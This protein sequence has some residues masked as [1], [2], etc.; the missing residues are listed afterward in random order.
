MK[1]WR[2]I[3]A[4]V[5]VAVFWGGIVALFALLWW[6]EGYQL[7]ILGVMFVLFF[8][9]SVLI[10]WEDRRS[11]KEKA[12]LQRASLDEDQVKEKAGQTAP[13]TLPEPLFNTFPEPVPK[14]YLKSVPT[15]TQ[16]LLLKYQK[17]FDCLFSYSLTGEQRLCIV[18]D[19]Y[20][21]LVIASA[22]SGKTTTLLGKYVF[23][24]EEG[25]A[26][27][28]EILVLAFNKAIQQEIKKKIKS[29][30]P[31][32][33]DPEVHTFHGF[34]NDLIKKA[35]GRKKVDR[36]AESSSDG[37]LNTANVRTII[38]KA[39]CEYPGIE[40]WISLFRAMCPRHQIEH[41]AKNR[42]EY[43]EAFG[44]Y[45]YDRK[46]FQYNGDSP[47]PRIPSL[48][49]MYWVR[50]Q[51]ELAIIN[52]LIIR[53]VK[54]EYER[55]YPGGKFTPDFYYPEIDLWHEHFAIRRDGTSFFPR[56]EEG[57]R[58]KM[59]FYEQEEKK[60]V[61]FLYTYIYQYDEGTLL[62]KIFQKLKKEGISF[63]PPSRKIIEKWLN[64]LKSDDTYNL[65]A[66]CIKLAKANDFSK[67]WR[68][69][70]RGHYLSF[71]LDSLRDKTRSKHFKRFFLPLLET[72]E[73]ILRDN[74]TIDFEDM[75][76]RPIRHLRGAEREKLL[77]CRYK[78]VLVDE[79]QDISRS[80]QDFLAGILDPET[81]LFVVGD[82]W[83]S[84][85]GFTG[86]NSMVMREFLE[87]GSPLAP[88]GWKSGREG[89]SYMPKVYKIQ[90]TFRNCKPISDVASEFIQK[91]PAQIRK[92]VRAR[93]PQD[94][95][96]AVY[97]CSVD[98]Y[99]N[100]NLKKVLDLIPR[101][102]EVKGVSILGRKNWEIEVI[103]PKNLMVC[104]RDLKITKGTIHRAKGLGN[105]IV[106]VVGMDSGMKGFPNYA[107]EDPLIS[108][109]LP[110]S[111]GYQ[112]SEERRVMYVAMTRAKEK[113]FLVNQSV[114]PSSFTEEVKEICRHL[115]IKFN[116]VVLREDVVG[117]C[118]QCLSKGMVE[119]RWKGG[120]V[121]RV[122]R[123]PP[124]YSIFLRCKNY[125]NRGCRHKDN[126]APCPACLTKGEKSRLEV[127]F[128]EGKKRYEVFCPRCD[129]RKD[130]DSFQR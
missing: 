39:K 46:G 30:V 68:I 44:S 112:N 45:P 67:E 63:N 97:V 102:D 37:L 78:Y 72:Y 98:G 117:P 123:N 2:R 10:S 74:G 130:Y 77:P 95:N 73:K 94:H 70:K 8:S 47:A 31:L 23:L 104:R 18:D 127:E 92:S 79:I 82:D 65:I 58:K 101:S 86:S 90:E 22:G 119:G 28:R 49:A 103:I 54:V 121:R 83:Q 100:E 124:P 34:G 50:S 15:K 57:Y 93:Q 35:E 81:R 53:G 21:T 9:L 111:D 36:L 60:G 5:G 26:T 61:N 107:G 66:K 75:I 13:K 51:Q 38:E 52:S 118:P 64:E 55:P 42:K 16:S 41:V 109:F 89:H 110:P 108:I 120:L 40:R 1:L 25:L 76:L 88:E 129:Y 19:S 7:A 84:I 105:D 14:T 62:E 32:A 12:Q 91:N 56:Y 125:A 87:S 122:R 114:S 115:D 116:N 126:N 71:R 99:D 85:Y 3:A 20:R 4:A 27:P 43:E 106:I 6:V 29:L 113:V 59:K 17:L 48:N 11:R 24:L 69:V 128:N 80:R 96:P 33:V